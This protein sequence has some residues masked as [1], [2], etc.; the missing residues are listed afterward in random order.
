MSSDTTTWLL[1]V[2]AGVIIFLIVRLGDL[3]KNIHQHVA[4]RVEE[5]KRR[6]V[7]AIRLDEGDK[8]RRE[9]T[10]QLDKWKSD[11][12]KGIR[13]D[14]ATRSHAVTVGKVSEHVAPYLPDFSFNPRDARF[15]GSPVD[16]IVFDGL[17]EGSVRQVVFIEVKAGSSTLT[18]RERQV[19]E[20]ILS[21]RV[22]WR[23]QRV[24]GG[25]L[26]DP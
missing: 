19:R 22:A 7:D 14:A 3:S 20:A 23:E 4:A 15:I 9:A 5:W 2:A 21:H 24:A 13:R 8:A 17:S 18:T 6:E 25:T 11:S 10:F 16:F 12:E 1:I 26:D